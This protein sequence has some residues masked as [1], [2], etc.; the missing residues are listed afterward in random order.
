MS[1]AV[2][3]AASPAETAATNRLHGA[4]CR[5]G[6]D[7]KAGEH[8]HGHSAHAVTRETEAAALCFNLMVHDNVRHLT[9][10]LRDA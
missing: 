7:R 1:N 8:L 5:Q 2:S 3:R 4:V 6:C 9:A 10:H